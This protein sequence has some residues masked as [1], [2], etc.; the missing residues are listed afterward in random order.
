MDLNYE[1]IK[2]R[3]LLRKK[4]THTHTLQ[5]MCK[6]DMNGCTLYM[7]YSFSREEMLLMKKK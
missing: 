3:C 5:F 2:S 7:E 6:K 4:N 1:F